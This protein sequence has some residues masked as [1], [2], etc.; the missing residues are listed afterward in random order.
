MPHELKTVNWNLAIPG[1][2]TSIPGIYLAS[3]SPLAYDAL[4]CSLRYTRYIFHQIQCPVFTRLSAHTEPEYILSSTSGLTPNA[5]SA[6]D[7]QQNM[8]MHN[9]V[10]D[11]EIIR[12]YY[13]YLYLQWSWRYSGR[14]LKGGN[15]TT[16]ILW[17]KVYDIVVVLLVKSAFSPAEHGWRATLQ[18]Q[19]TSIHFG[20]SQVGF[21][22]RATIIV[23]SHPSRHWNLFVTA[24]LLDREHS[25]NPCSFENR[26]WVHRAFSR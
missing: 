14:M 5:Y 7:V 11:D 2:G 3:K 13:H 12:I 21:W 4:W 24:I 26:L 22:R 17:I 6:D 8:A 15:N 9:A 20:N 25:G 1:I 23:I 10:A 16:I 19:F 18:Q